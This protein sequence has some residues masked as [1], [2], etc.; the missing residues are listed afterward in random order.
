LDIASK[1]VLKQALI[2]YEGTFIIVSHD[3]EFLDG[4]TNRIWE[5]YNQT[6]KIHHYTVQ[7]FLKK[8]AEEQKELN[9]SE[10]VV[11]TAP[12]HKEEK[13]IIQPSNS[14]EKEIKRIEKEISDLESKIEEMNI[15]LAELDYSDE[16]KANSILTEYETLKLNLEEKM[17][18]WENLVG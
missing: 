4:L 5:I 13:S 12:V 2:N 1:E 3:R 10:K 18:I 8:K 7:E 17:Q 11:K 6:L 9:Q 15:I 16:S 14:N